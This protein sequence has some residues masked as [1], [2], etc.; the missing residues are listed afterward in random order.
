[1]DCFLKLLHSV[2]SLEKRLGSAA[3]AVDRASFRQYRQFARWN[4]SLIRRRERTSDNCSYIAYSSQ[5]V[6][7][8]FGGTYGNL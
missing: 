3:T 5:S 1:M 4:I 8:K 2:E 6:C 7:V